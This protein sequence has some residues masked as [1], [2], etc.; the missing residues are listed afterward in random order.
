MLTAVTPVRVA[1]TQLVEPAPPVAGNGVTEGDAVPVGML[2][3]TVASPV[4]ETPLDLPLPQAPSG[5]SEESPTESGNTLAGRNGQLMVRG[6]AVDLGIPRRFQYHFRISLLETFDD[7][8]FLDKHNKQSDFITVIQPGVTLSIGDVENRTDRFVRFDYSAGIYLFARRGGEDNVQHLLR[9]DAQYRFQK[10]TLTAT[11]EVQILNGADLSGIDNGGTQVSRVNLDVA[12][13]TSLNIYTTSLRADYPLTGKTSLDLGLLYSLSDYETL[14]NSEVFSGDVYVNYALGSKL[15]V[16]GGISGGYAPAENPTPDETFEQ[17]SLRLNYVLTGKISFTGSAGVES[18]Q[19]GGRGGSSVT[20]VFDFSALYL[21][22]DGTTVGFSAN[23][24]V[25][26][27][28]ING[29]QNYQSTGFSLSVRQR[30]YT[31]FSLSLSGGYEND[32]YV[33]ALDGVNATRD[34]NYFFIQTGVDVTLRD[35]I[36]AG[37]VYQHRENLSSGSVDATSFSDNQFSA[38]ITFSF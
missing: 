1:A 14:I 13:R 28:A 31:R 11:Q 24:R 35:H 32:H 36:S 6:T 21:P 18:R 2:S 9:L 19:T 29:G 10:L 30:F 3:A 17:I 15:T 34:D 27:S 5:P 26:I 12:G 16:G 22:F 38:R 37:L 33:S 25:L 20:P 8:V 23:R 7:N 4:P